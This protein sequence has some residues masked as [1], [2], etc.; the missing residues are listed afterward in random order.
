MPASTKKGTMSAYKPRRPS[1][2]GDDYMTSAT[3]KK[4]QAEK[5]ERETQKKTNAAYNAAA[6]DYR[7]GGPVDA[8]YLGGPVMTPKSTP[9]KFGG[10]GK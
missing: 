10:K 9:F 1:A 8:Y 5:D 7:N 4:L 3:R 6:K 2:T